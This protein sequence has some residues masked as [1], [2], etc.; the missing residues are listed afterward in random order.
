MG[1]GGGPQ[2]L[3]VDLGAGEDVV[4]DGVAVEVGGGAGGAAVGVGEGE[5]AHGDD[6][7]AEVVHGGLPVGG[8][9]FEGGEAGEVAAGVGAR[10]LPAAG[11]EGSGA[12]G[13]VGDQG[14]LCGQVGQWRGRRRERPG[15]DGPGGGEVEVRGVGHRGRLLGRDER[16]AAGGGRRDGRGGTGRDG[17]GDTVAEALLDVLVG[18]ASEGEQRGGR[19]A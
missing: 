4:V 8:A 18:A 7:E 14:L 19:G 11:Q 16:G 1:G 10:R 6:V 9:V 12:E 13:G 5:V 15:E 17:G 3:D 2:G